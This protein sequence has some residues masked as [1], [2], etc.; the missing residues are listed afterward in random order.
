MRRIA[1]FLPYWVGDAVM[2]T[3]ALRS[4]RGGFGLNCQMVGILRPS[5]AEV[6]AGTPWLD[7]FWT[8]ESKRRNGQPGKWDLPAKLRL[9][10]FDTAI[11]FPNSFETAAIAWLGGIRNRLGYARDGRSPLLT[12][13]LPVTRDGW[14]LRPTPAVDYYLALPA[15]LGF[16]TTNRRMAL[17][18][19]ARDNDQYSQFIRE[20]RLT[21]DPDLSTVVINNSGAFGETKLWPPG[22]LLRLCRL[23][24][25]QQEIRIVLHC[26]PAERQAANTIAEELSSPRVVSMGRA[27]RLPLS[28]SKSLIARADLVISTDSGPRHVA[29]AFDRPVISLFGPTDVTWTQTYNQE[30]VVMESNLPCRPCWKPRCPLGHHACMAGLTAERVYRAA[31]DLLRH[32]GTGLPVGKQDQPT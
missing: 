8:F 21:V 16:T 30:E 20:A 19:T 13:R 1:V 2:S 4:L 7:E 14:R 10:R 11:L 9:G 6:L 12:S 27:G 18:L 15:A 5:I 23:L 26:G 28:L 3:P 25:T 22:E 29:A 31:L 24:L 17:H 32:P